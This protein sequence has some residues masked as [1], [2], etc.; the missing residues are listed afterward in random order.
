MRTLAFL[1]ATA[2]LLTATIAVAVWLSQ[3]PPPS[4]DPAE[5]FVSPEDRQMLRRRQEEPHGH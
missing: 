1:L 2:L 5:P 3:D 4:D